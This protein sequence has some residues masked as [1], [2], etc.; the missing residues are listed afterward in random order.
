VDVVIESIDFDDAYVPEW[1]TPYD[2]V[3]IELEMRRPALE[4]STAG[5]MMRDCVLQVVEHEGPV[6]PEVIVRRLRRRW[7]ADNLKSRFRNAVDD[8]IRYLIRDK[9]IRYVDNTFLVLASSPPY[10]IVRV[11]VSGNAST[12]R[13]IDEVSRRELRSAM[14]YLLREGREIGRSDLCVRVARIF[15][16]SRTGARIIEQLDEQFEILLADN[17]IVQDDAGVCR[18]TPTSE[19]I[20]DKRMRN[21]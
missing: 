21:E 17:Y 12:E 1:V 16:W 18:L 19:E 20:I 4:M 13:T 14:I 10:A 9:K 11:P 7:N 15:G 3:E 6:H 8:A 5:R 2:V